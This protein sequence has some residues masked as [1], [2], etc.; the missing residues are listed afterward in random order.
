MEHAVLGSVSH[1]RTGS[2]SRQP[3]ALMSLAGGLIPWAHSTVLIRRPG[4]SWLYLCPLLSLCLQR[5]QQAFQLIT[6]VPRSEPRRI[7]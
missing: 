7:T 5:E 1:R 4:P 3:P 2:G 6:E